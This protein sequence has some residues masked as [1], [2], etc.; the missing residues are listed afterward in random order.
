M[1]ST[2]RA[3]QPDDLEAAEA[4]HGQAFAARGER[5]WT[6]REMA[7]LLASPG[8]AGCLAVDAEGTAVG[9]ALFRTVADEAELLTIAVDPACRRRGIGRQLLRL[10]IACARKRGGHSLFLEVGADNAD[11]RR[12]Y[13]QTGF[14]AVGRRAA[15][16]ARPARPPE[17]AVVM[18]LA[19]D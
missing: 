17:D 4:L 7:D 6:R 9:F 3:L 16:Y 15:Y 5:G 14:R 12:L 18:R 8:V 13:D 19:L 2:V 10:V 11:A 1:M